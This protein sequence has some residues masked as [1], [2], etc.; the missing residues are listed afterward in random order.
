M[1]VSSPSL[2]RQLRGLKVAIVHDWLAT[3]GGAERVLEQLLRLFPAADLFAV[4]DFLPDRDRAWLHD[5]P[6]QTT[7][8]QRLPGAA[9]HFRRYLA[10]MPMAVEQL[11]L[12]GYD[13]ILSSS[14]AVAKGVLTGPDQ[15]HVSYVHSPMRYAWDMQHQYLRRS[16]LERGVRGAMARALLHYLRLWDVRTAPGVDRFIANSAYIAR[17]I[18]KSYGREAAVVYP[19][20]DTERFALDPGPR[21][22]FYLLVS[23]LVPYKRVDLVVEAFAAMPER[24]LRLIGD[25]PEASRIRAMARGKPNIEW[26]G[27]QSSQVVLAQMRRARGFVYVGEEDFGI[28]LVEAQSCGTPVIALARGGAVETVRDGHSGVLFDHQSAQGVREA[29]RRFEATPGIWSPAR[30]RSWAQAFSVERFQRHLIAEL[31]NAWSA[32]LQ[33]RIPGAGSPGA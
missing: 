7:F 31:D 17:R 29:I 5:R 3:Y 6:V 21:D 19:P 28:V 22:D 2:P 23:R 18:A 30:I 4:V 14:H 1:T 15:L 8:I 27:W 32:R 9:R 25:G 20:V 12:G 16:G 11:D 26:L 13:L 10:L 33:G 24:R